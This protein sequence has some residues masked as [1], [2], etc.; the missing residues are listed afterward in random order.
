[1]L[2][3]YTCNVATRRSRFMLSSAFGRSMK[4]APA[5]PFLSIIFYNFAKSLPKHIVCCNSF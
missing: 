5:N 1:M 2:S 4:T 3:P